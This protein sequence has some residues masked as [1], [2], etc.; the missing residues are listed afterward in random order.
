[1]PAACHRGPGNAM[2]SAAPTT[3][4]TARSSCLAPM[5]R[6]RKEERARSRRAQL[7]NPLALLRRAAPQRRMPQLQMPRL[8][9]RPNDR[10]SGSLP[11]TPWPGLQVMSP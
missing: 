2:H 8:L 6:T 11:G 9:L 7:E 10:Q 4:D 5:A 3:G 1:M